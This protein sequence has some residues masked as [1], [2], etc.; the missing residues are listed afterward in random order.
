MNDPSISQGEGEGGRKVQIT[1]SLPSDTLARLDEL[2]HEKRGY[3]RSSLVWLAVEEFLARHTTRRGTGA[4][5][6]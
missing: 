3:S 5:R 6:D 1:F 4:P 2:T